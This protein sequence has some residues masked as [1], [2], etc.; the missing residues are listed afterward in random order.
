[1]RKGRGTSVAGADITPLHTGT[2]ALSDLQETLE[3]LDSGKST[4]AKVLVD[5]RT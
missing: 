3:L 2:I 1:M 4:H 5:P